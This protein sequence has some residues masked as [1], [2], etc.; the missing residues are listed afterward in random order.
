MKK[1]FFLTICILAN[2][3]AWGQLKL[4]VDTM[5]T[6]YVGFDFGTVF[7]SDKLSSENGMHDLYK[8]PYLNFGLDA[9]Y[10]FK[11]NWLV[12][13]DGSLIFGND[14]RDKEKRMP[15]VFSRDAAPIII[16]S[17]G[18]DA[19]PSVYNRA[20]SLRLGGGRI[21]AL[22]NNPNSGLA[23]RFFG[24]FMQQK[25]IFKMYQERA[26]QLED[27]YARLYD[28]KR[29]G[30]TITESIGYWYMSNTSNYFNFYI[31]LEATQCWNRSAREYVI[32]DLMGLY[33]PDDTHYFDMLFTLKLCWLFP[34]AGKT[35]YDYYFF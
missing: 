26:P 29:R 34:L 21:F 9:G 33:G 30:M 14:V 13:I 24:G 6:P 16:G 28:H 32:D 35:A 4:T 11:S 3:L 2:G 23:L 15:A 5:A 20:L 22:G 8:N 27:D 18:T 19:H 25:T 1:L 31:A 10:K 12:S 7:A 17:N